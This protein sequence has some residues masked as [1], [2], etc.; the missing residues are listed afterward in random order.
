MSTTN[1]HQFQYYCRFSVARGEPRIFFHRGVFTICRRTRWS[2]SQFRPTARQVVQLVPWNVLHTT[3]STDLC[4]A[5]SFP[6]PRGELMLC[7]K[8]GFVWFSSK[9]SFDVVRS[10]G[11]NTYNYA[12]PVRRDV[13]SIGGNVFG[14]EADNVTIRFVTDNA[15]PWF[16]HWQ[17]LSF[18]RWF[19][20]SD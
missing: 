8:R 10:A 12:N 4:S 7:L 9:H 6:S 17:V 2:R 14:V 5:A 18:R 16:L 11:T 1:H 20:V 19:H 3:C 15:G 13:V